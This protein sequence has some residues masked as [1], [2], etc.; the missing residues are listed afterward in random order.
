MRSKDLKDKKIQNKVLLLMVLVAAVFV[1]VAV[2]FG[3][4]L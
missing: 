3:S 4:R 2:A 1:I